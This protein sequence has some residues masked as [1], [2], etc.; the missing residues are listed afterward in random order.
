MPRKRNITFRDGWARSRISLAAYA[1][2][3]DA[4]LPGELAELLQL[5]RCFYDPADKGPPRADIRATLEVLESVPPD[6]LRGALGALDSWTL[7]ELEA[8]ALRLWRLTHPGQTE[9]PEDVFDKWR[10]APE[11]VHALAQ[12]TLDRLPG[13]RG[14]RRATRW[15]DARLMR[16]LVALWQRTRAKRLSP[17]DRELLDWTEHNDY[18]SLAKFTRAMFDRAGRGSIDEGDLSR[19]RTAALRRAG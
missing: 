14:G 4:E 3:E 5:A 15:A 13:A 18:S 11:H 17:A 1:Q 19:L 9:V 8:A 16:E 2:L 12:A 6:L 10:W 7:A